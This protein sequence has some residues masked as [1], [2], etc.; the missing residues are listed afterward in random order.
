MST[1][2]LSFDNFGALEIHLRSLKSKYAELIKKYEETLGGI[3]RE[4]SRTANPKAQK[5]QEKWAL[6]M[7]QALASAKDKK[8]GSKAS[9]PPKKPA[10]TKEK[11]EA[12]AGEWIALDPMSVFVG[13]KSRG[14]AEIYFDTVN[15]LRENIGKINLALSI[16]NTLKAK[17]ATSGSASLI[18]SFVSDIP[19]KMVLKPADENTAKKYSMTF[20][21]AVQA[22][23]ATQSL[24]VK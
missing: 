4:T 2:I 13:P 8:V 17:A 10:A 3:L 24:A 14:M 15:V 9:S 20:N 22:M 21:F 18:V 16:C 23:P 7:Q 12:P 1:Q 19:T 6:D 11:P 5:V